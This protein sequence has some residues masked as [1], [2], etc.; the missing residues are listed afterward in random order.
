[1]HYGPL[2]LYRRYKLPLIISENGLSCNDII[3]RDGQVHDPKRIDFLHRYLTELSKAIA[4]GAPV[5]G[6]MQWSF[7]DNFEWANGS[8]ERFG[9]IY[10]DYPT[11]R[12]IPKDSARWYA[13]VIATNGACLEED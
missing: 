11:L 9:I 12:S 1:M 13:N 4:E 3:F 7:L 10:V 6:Y 8:D 2:F 5:K